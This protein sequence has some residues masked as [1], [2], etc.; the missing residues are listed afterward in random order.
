MNLFNVAC[1][2]RL[3]EMIWDASSVLWVLIRQVELFLVSVFFIPR[4]PAAKIDPFVFQMAARFGC[5]D[6]KSSS[7]SDDRVKKRA[8]SR[9]WKNLLSFKEFT[10]WAGRIKLDVSDR[11]RFIKRVMIERAINNTVIHNQLSRN[12]PLIAF[13]TCAWIK[14]V[15]FI[16][17]CRAS[18]RTGWFPVVWS[19]LL[20]L[21]LS[22][23]PIWKM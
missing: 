16:Y 11:L 13:T 5:S 1:R 7:S 20:Y 21:L 4:I 15:I 22:G 18:D 8:F 2:V 17:L 23:N 19:G 9:S 3:V 10:N 6:C 12:K 14:F